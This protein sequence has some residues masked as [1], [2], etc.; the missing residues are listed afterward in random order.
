MNSDFY[1]TITVI[2]FIDLVFAHYSF[3][4][5]HMMFVCVYG[6]AF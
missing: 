6:P 2:M 4:Y 1:T 5:S 3:K